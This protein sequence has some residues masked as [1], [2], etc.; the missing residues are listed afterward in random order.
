MIKT[1]SRVDGNGKRWVTFITGIANDL[2]MWDGQV[3]AL[4][5]DFRILRYDLRGHGG[6]ET[7][8]GD[9]SIDTLVEDLRTL[10]ESRGI[11]KTSLVGLGLGGA[12]AQAF[13]IQHPG[14][15]ERLMP[16]CCR[17]RMVPDF[18]AMWHKLR[19]TVQKNGLETI[20]EPTVQRWFSEDFKLA[21]PEVLAKIR[22]MV[23]GVTQAGYLGVTAAFL[24]LDV[25]DRLGNITV[26]TLYV[27]GANDHLGGPPELMKGLAAKVSG[28]RHVSVPG[29]AHIAN[30]QNPEGFN[31]VLKEFLQ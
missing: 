18:A 2:S 21:H 6:S 13:A 23:R 31:Q 26:P 9:Y 3:P 5:R 24:R 29:A 4:E 25:E 20:V 10:L 22:K 15:V 28:A 17:A 16:C 7:T 19:E 1:H 12:I 11:E 27:S 8:P 30:I 14:R